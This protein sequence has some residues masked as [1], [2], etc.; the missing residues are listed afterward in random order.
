MHLYQKIIS[1]NG[2]TDDVTSVPKKMHPSIKRD[3]IM[4]LWS[5]NLHFGFA[6][7]YPLSK[8]AR[9]VS[10]RWCEAERSLRMT[11]YNKHHIIIKGQS[12]VPPTQALPGH[13]CLRALA[14]A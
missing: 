11:T 14:K 8:H 4:I 3:R 1:W 13:P 5:M 6:D 2:M 12:K 9:A 7:R 10:K